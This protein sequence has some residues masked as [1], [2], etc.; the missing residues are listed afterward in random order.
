MT[1][2]ELVIYICRHY[3]NVMLLT[4][5]ELMRINKLGLE[6]YLADLQREYGKGNEAEDKAA[7]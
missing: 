7:E 6:Q 2:S 4:H 5:D 3:G 1:K